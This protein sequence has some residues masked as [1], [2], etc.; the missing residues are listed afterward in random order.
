MCANDAFSTKSIYQHLERNVA[1]SH[2][3]WIWKAQIPLK[4]K[5][6]LW[7]LFKNAILTRDNLKKCKC[8]GSPLCLYVACGK[9]LL[10]FIVFIQRG[11]NLTCFSFLPFV[12]AFGM[13]ETM[14]LLMEL[15]FVP[16]W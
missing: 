15:L 16:L 5:I 7:L 1:C 10:C 14:Y 6:F 11:E 4:L 2:N 9:V 3:K 8:L 12:E 13:S